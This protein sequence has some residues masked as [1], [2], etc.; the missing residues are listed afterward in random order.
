[1]KINLSIRAFTL[2]ELIIT[3]ILVA[4]V[5]LGMLSIN[6]VL[7]TNNQDYGQKYLVKSSTQSTL[8]HI[9]NNATLAVGSGTNISGMVDQGI[10]Y[11][12]S[13][14]NDAN[15]F[16]IHQD[17]NNTPGNFSDDIWFCYTWY[18]PTIDPN[19]AYQIKYCT[20]PYTYNLSPYRGAAACADSTAT[21][22]GTALKN[23]VPD[24]SFN[25]D[26]S[27]AGT[28]LIFSI[29]ITNCLNNSLS[30]CSSSGPSGQSVS[31]AASNPEV[32]ISGS[33]TPLQE[34]MIN[35]Y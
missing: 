21:Y 24:I 26:G 35:N 12:S 33:V 34:S 2:I 30:S 31:D 7:S 15:T 25:T 20:M 28:P 19:Y 5:V 1:M 14:V 11:G 8:N 29:K 9:L 3:T 13:G 27:T 18:D 32:Q 23:P 6:S 10:I 22:L 4:V 16:C 17:P